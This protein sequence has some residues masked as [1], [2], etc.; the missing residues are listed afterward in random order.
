MIFSGDGHAGAPAEAYR[1]YLDEPYR[2]LV[3]DLVEENELYMAIAGTPSQPTAEALEVFDD[4]GRVYQ[5]IRYAVDPATGIVGNSLTDNTWFDAATNVIKSLPAGSKLFTKTV[6]DSLG[7]P[8][9]RYT[10]YDLAE[11][12]YPG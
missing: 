10:G 8:K 2:A 6:Y 9:T 1:P 7:R 5:T 11:T 3:D 12:G 4:R